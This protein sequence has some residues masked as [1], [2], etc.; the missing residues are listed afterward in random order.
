MKKLVNAKKGGNLIV[1]LNHLLELIFYCFLTI[2]QFLIQVQYPPLKKEKK[3]HFLWILEPTFKRPELY[4]KDGGPTKTDDLS[5][6]GTKNQKHDQVKVQSLSL[7]SIQDDL[8]VSI[9]EKKLNRTTTK[10]RSIFN[11][12]ISIKVTVL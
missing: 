1:S 2:E 11:L 9:K 8:I 4:I 7:D 6:F 3:L 5:N 10:Q 12:S